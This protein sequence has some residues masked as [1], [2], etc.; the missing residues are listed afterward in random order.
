MIDETVFGMDQEEFREVARK[1]CP[2]LT[3]EEFDVMW[4][5]FMQ[6]RWKRRLH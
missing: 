1:L 5:D 6:D 4:E 2:D 3:D